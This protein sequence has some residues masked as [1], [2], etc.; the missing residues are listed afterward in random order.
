MDREGD[1][2]GGAL[3]GLWRGGGCEDWVKI[4]WLVGCDTPGDMVCCLR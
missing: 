3:M 1:R 4:A 2:N